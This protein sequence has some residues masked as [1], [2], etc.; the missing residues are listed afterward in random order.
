MCK[1]SQALQGASDDSSSDK[2]TNID[3]GGGFRLIEEIFVLKEER[4]RKLKQLRWRRSIFRLPIPEVLY[5]SLTDRA[6][7]IYLTMRGYACLCAY[8]YV[9]VRLL[10]VGDGRL[11]KEY[12]REECSV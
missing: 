8:V 3:V 1:G 6:L 12:M 11:S 2:S 4:R 5:C 10:I 7:F 9:Y